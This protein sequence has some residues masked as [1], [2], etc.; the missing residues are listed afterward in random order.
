M[1]NYVVEP[2]YR[3]DNLGL[4]DFG[5]ED[6][7]LDSL[8][9]EHTF[10]S[11]RLEQ[12]SE[13]DLT[14]PDAECQETQQDEASSSKPVKFEIEEAE[15]IPVAR[16]PEFDYATG[17]ERPDWS[18]VVEYGPPIGNP[19]DIEQAVVQSAETLNRITSLLKAAKVSRPTRARKLSEGEYL[20]LD[21]CIEARLNQRIGLTPDPRI[22][23]QWVRQDRD[24]SVLLLLDISES[25]SDLVANSEET[26]LKLELKASALLSHAMAGL[27]DPFALAAFCSNNRDDV[28]YFRIK[29]FDKPFDRQT[30]AHFAGLESGLSTRMGTAIRHAGTEL[31]RQVTYRKLLLIITDGEPSDLD[32]KDPRYLIEDARRSVQSLS[33][34]GIDVF[35]VGL[36][37]DATPY[38]DTIFGSKN[39]V[40]VDRIEKLPEKLPQLYLR[41][42]G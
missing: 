1:N 36:A 13:D 31:A 14:P 16:Y 6:I 26:V 5:D 33:H 25:T 18:T 8:E 2:P 19:A 37:T 7:P 34:Q 32:I 11:V 20:D 38:L 28:R 35:C 39:S 15:G 21:A 17:Y 4:W 24:L 3:D 27:G 40:I 23:G 10:T 22:Y 30:Y 9:A 42:A 12:K 41:M 29:D